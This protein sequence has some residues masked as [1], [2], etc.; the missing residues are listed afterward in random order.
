MSSPPKKIRVLIAE[1]EPETRAR[2]REIIV[3]FG[4]QP[5]VVAS[6]LHALLQLQDQR[7][8]VVLLGGLLPETRRSEI[9]RFARGIASD[10]HPRIVRLAEITRDAV[11]A[12]I[13]GS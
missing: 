4:C 9:A 7:P 11:A 3:S 13:F 1:D 10:Y 8:E 5:I 6:G 12:A 2:L